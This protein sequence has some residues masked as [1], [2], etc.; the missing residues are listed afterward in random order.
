MISK[1]DGTTL[2]LNY[3]APR[4]NSGGGV[5]N[6]K[7]ELLAIISKVDIEDGI[8]YATSVKAFQSIN[9]TFKSIKSP[10]LKTD[11]YDYS[12]CETNETLR[13]WRNIIKSGDLKAHE[14]HALFLGLCEKV[15]RK[16]ITTEEA[17]Y[18]YMKNRKRVFGF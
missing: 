7:G 9:E 6:Q 11:N 4:G 5:F 2:L 18:L 16:E 10:T 1:I 14:L 15:K 3:I 12:Y 13:V 17:D 8:T